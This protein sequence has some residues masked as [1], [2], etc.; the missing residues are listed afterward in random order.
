MDEE[1]L[2]FL[3]DRR[4]ASEAVRIRTFSVWLHNREVTVNVRDAGVGAPNR[5]MAEAYFAGT[6]GEDRHTGNDGYTLGNPDHTLQGALDNI[7]WWQ[8]EAEANVDN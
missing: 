1:V 4:G 3:N 6:R 5:F 2:A 8:L 7:H